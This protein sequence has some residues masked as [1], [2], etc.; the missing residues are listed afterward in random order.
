[1]YPHV[2]LFITHL[3]EKRIPEIAMILNNNFINDCEAYMS[4]QFVI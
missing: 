1:M 4:K 2:V 3:T